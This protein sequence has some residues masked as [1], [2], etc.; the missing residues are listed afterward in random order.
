MSPCRRRGG[1]PYQDVWRQGKLVRAGRRDCAGRFEAIVQHVVEPRWGTPPLPPEFTVL[2]VGAWDGYFARRFHEAGAT[3]TMV[4]ERPLPDISG[5]IRIRY[6]RQRL[7][8]ASVTKLRHHNLT[9][10]LSVFHHMP[11]WDA[12]YGAL[13]ERTDVLVVETAVPEET[14]PEVPQT[15]TLKITGPRIEAVYKEMR[16]AGRLIGTTRGPNG[17]DRPLFE[18]VP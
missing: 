3:C 5:Y 13:L 9:L 15:P 4:D 7:D 12:V 14:G 8:W 2:D 18:I 10:A 16:R 6:W 11:D 17:V 1:A